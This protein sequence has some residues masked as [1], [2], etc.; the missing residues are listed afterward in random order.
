MYSRRYIRDL[1]LLLEEKRKRKGFVGRASKRCCL[2]PLLVRSGPAEELNYS[3]YVASIYGVIF[4][5][6]SKPASCRLAPDSS[7]P[8]PTDEPPEVGS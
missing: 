3:L 6:K 4:L 1:D 5:N 8:T 2:G 7:R